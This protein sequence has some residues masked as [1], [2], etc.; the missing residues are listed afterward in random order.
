[1]SSHFKIRV[2][3]PNIEEEE[4][5]AVYNAVKEELKESMN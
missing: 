5:K 3:E 2:A 4:V 1:L